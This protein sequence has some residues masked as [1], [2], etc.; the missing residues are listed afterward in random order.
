MS[1]N[2]KRLERNFQAKLV[3]EIKT[4]FPGCFVLKNDSGYLQ[5]VPDLIVLHQDR[6]ATLECKRSAKAPH[7]PNQDIYV[8]Q[9]NEMSFSRFIYPENKEEVLN[10]LEQSFKAGGGSCVS[11]CE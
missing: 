9:M 3:K 8:E 6:W 10:E 1:M 11:R 2:S 4:R 7:Q 5:G